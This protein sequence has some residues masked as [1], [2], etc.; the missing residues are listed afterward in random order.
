MPFN[1]PY[2]KGKVRAAKNAARPQR[3]KNRSRQGHIPRGTWLNVIKSNH[4]LRC[5][6]I[7]TG[8]DNKEVIQILER[9]MSGQIYN[10]HTRL[11]QHPCNTI[12][13]PVTNRNYSPILINATVGAV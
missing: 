3:E 4:I 13:I 12:H 1:V 6:L 9:T 8:T 7:N 10:L 5:A 11:H 2:P